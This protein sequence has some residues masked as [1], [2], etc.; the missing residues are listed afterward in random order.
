[1]KS[2]VV[3]KS[4]DL[5]LWSKLSRDALKWSLLHAAILG[6]LVYDVS[7]KC[8]YADSKLYWIEY[9]SIAIVSAS[10]FYYIVRYIYYSVIWEP[11]VGTSDQKRLLQFE[12]KDNSFVIRKKQ[13]PGPVS[14]PL[15]PNA[16]L[17]FSNLSCS[18]NDSMNL[19]GYSSP[20]QSHINLSM[21]L[22]NNNMAKQQ[23]PTFSSP[24]LAS[25]AGDQDFFV[26]PASLNQLL[27]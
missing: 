22:S 5:R 21:N 25:N 9:F 20:N 13:S 16:S 15:L 4:L 19:S 7:N 26:E 10:L 8:K 24:Y 27:E 18:F 2:P 17:N 3:N 14:S 1:M 23:A 6:I 12:D 11:V